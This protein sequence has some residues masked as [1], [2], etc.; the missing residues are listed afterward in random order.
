VIEDGHHTVNERVNVILFSYL[1]SG[2]ER[3]QSFSGQLKSNSIE[4]VTYVPSLI[5]VL[6]I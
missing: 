2:G 6:D 3:L 5:R 1:L 4:T